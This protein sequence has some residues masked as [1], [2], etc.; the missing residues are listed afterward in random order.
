MND[1]I[2]QLAFAFT[3]MGPPEIIEISGKW[4]TSRRNAYQNPSQAG[5]G[6]GLFVEVVDARWCG[7]LK[8]AVPLAGFAFLD[9]PTQTFWVKSLPSA[10]HP[11]VEVS[12]HARAGY[13]PGRATLTGSLFGA[14]LPA[15]PI[16]CGD[17]LTKDCNLGS[18]ATGTGS[19]H[20]LAEVAGAA[21]VLIVFPKTLVK[22][23]RN[24]VWHLRSEHASSL[25]GPLRIFARGRTGTVRRPDAGECDAV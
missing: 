3:A 8:C 24:R 12:L 11:D 19:A 1:L 15:V 6:I 10:M 22:V 25:E 14:V 20:A 13:L 2:Q 4:S 9:T 16:A 17:D 5:S 21:F 18:M 23:G 7:T